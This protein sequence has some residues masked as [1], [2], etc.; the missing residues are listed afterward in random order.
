VTHEDFKARME[1]LN[2]EVLGYSEDLAREFEKE[3]DKAILSLEK[4]LEYW[5][6]RLAKNNQI[7]L[8]EA[9]K[10]LRGKALKEFQWT[11]EEYIRHGEENGIN[12]DWRKELENASARI[13]ISWIE[14]AE[15]QL[16]N[17]A[18]MLR[19]ESQQTAT[20]AMSKVYEEGYWRTAFEIEKALKIGVD[21]PRVD[22]E[23]IKQ[24]ILHPWTAD[25]DS[26]MKRITTNT[27]KLEQRVNTELTQML[28]RGD[29]PR[30]AI[31]TIAEEF[32]V[33]KRHAARLIMTESAAMASL[34][35]KEVYKDLNVERYE[36]L[37]TLDEITCPKCR[38]LDGKIFDRTAYRVGVTANPFH[39][40]CRCT[41]VPYYE[42]FNEG[43]MRAARDEDGK[44]FELPAS[45]KY[46]EFRKM[47]E[48]RRE[49][50]DK[51]LEK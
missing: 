34:A 33:A 51:K 37:V 32:H 21:L 35:S 3:I 27:V 1:R 38:P 50:K 18:E 5:F 4:D 40:S 12:A 26:Y 20:Q 2:N 49:K 29:P 48:E 30:K 6:A 42:D 11:V 23:I 9:R 10:L 15:I 47:M 45:V 31:D 7:S 22:A 36:I 8:A 17:L 13:H 39:P 14:S 44:T 41:T 25:G 46:E 16:K 43:S 24:K 19:E 28:M